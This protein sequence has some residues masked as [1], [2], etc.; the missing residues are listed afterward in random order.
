MRVELC[1]EKDG[2]QRTLGELKPWAYCD[3][4]GPDIEWDLGSMPQY[5]RREKDHKGAHSGGPN[6]GNWE[7]ALHSNSIKT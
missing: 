5:C 6:G 2:K 7:D 3:A 4:R 1:E